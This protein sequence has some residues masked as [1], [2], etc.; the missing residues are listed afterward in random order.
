MFQK[1]HLFLPTH[2]GSHIHHVT[3]GF[4]QMKPSNLIM[5]VLVL[6][7]L[8]VLNHQCS[9]FEKRNEGVF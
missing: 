7:L 9:E 4:G 1:L 2:I 5:T 6:V 8:S 3:N